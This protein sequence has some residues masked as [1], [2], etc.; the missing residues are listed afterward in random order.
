[1]KVLVTGAT[2]FTGSYVV[3]AL[4]QR[5][6]NV[7]CFVRQSSN[8]AA[9]PAGQIEIAW[10]EL[11][12]PDSLEA[13][14]SGCE[15]LVNLV[16]LG[17][18][19]ARG[20]V[21]VALRAGVRRS[22]FLST[23]SLFTQLDVSTRSVRLEAERIIRESGLAYTILRPTM[24]YG[25]SRDRNMCRLIRYLQRWP[26]VPVVGGRNSLQ[27]PVFVA[28]VASAVCLALL[29]RKTINKSYNIPG[30]TALTLGKIIDTICVK[31]KRNPLKLRV[32]AAPLAALLATAERLSVHLPVKSEQILRLNE[33]KA[34]DYSE[35]RLD[36]DYK[37]RSFDEGIELELAEMGLVSSK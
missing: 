7:R 20:I 36:F 11:N 4:L 1:M 17:F 10:G 23:T 12:D 16:S 34:F 3:T 2:G 25:S 18:G 33:D 19:H 31:M 13:A 24:I 6:A 32:P 29:E 21:A 14:L 27:Q 9:L 8:A 35:A 5:G 22:V 37:P 26:V 30:G 28:D 15:A